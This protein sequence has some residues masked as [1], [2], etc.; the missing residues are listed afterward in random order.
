VNDCGNSC[1]AGFQSDLL[2]MNRHMARHFVSWVNVTLRVPG[3]GGWNGL[4]VRAGDEKTA[5]GRYGNL[6]RQQAVRRW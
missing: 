1:K 6:R 4:N 2:K 5:S 3:R